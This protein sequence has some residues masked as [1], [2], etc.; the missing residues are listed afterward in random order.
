MTMSISSGSML[1]T[2]PTGKTKITRKRGDNVTSLTTEELRATAE[3]SA[4]KS[5]QQFS[6][7]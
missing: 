7:V 5:T 6:N 3:T 4:L 2:G 1:S